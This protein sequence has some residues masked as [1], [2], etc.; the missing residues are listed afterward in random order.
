MTGKVCP[1]DKK[2]CI[3]EKCEVFLEDTGICAFRL[4]GRTEKV[5]TASPTAKGNE[6][7][8]SRPFKAHLFD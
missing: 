8:S 2:P 5:K 7:S 3:R 4:I 6:R 1:F